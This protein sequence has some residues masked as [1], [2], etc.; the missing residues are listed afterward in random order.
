M[1]DQ[2]RHLRPIRAEEALITR[3]ELA[4]LLHVSEDTIDRMR[5]KGMPSI[6]WGRR[7]VRFR[8]SDCLSWLEGHDH[9]REAA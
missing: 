7:L 9:G 2:G 5:E 3:V 6:R 4:A 1:S 8:P